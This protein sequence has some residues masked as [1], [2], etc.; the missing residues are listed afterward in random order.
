MKII[1]IKQDK[2]I[3]K[4]SVILFCTNYGIFKFLSVSKAISFHFWVSTLLS[5]NAAIKSEQN[6][7]TWELCED[8]SGKPP[9]G[10]TGEGQ[11]GG[12]SLEWQEFRI[13]VSLHTFQ[14]GLKTT[15]PEAGTSTRHPNSPFSSASRFWKGDIGC[16]V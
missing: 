6:I 1:N 3:P 10:L 14:P 4:K 5:L 13:F 12:K 15:N 9:A 7:Y 8:S 11:Q 16:S 2:I